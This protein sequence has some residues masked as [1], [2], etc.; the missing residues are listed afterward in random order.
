MEVNL[1][2]L[3]EIQLKNGQILKLRKPVANDAEKMIE[4]LN[5]VGGESDNLLFGKGEFLLTVEQEVE[6]INRI[7]NDTNT[8]MIVGIIND[9]IVSVAQIS[10]PSRK[11]I[12][13]NSE[14]AISVRRDYWGVGIGS[15][16]MEELIQFAKKHSIIKNISL[17]VK[18]SNSKAIR[19]YEKYGFVKVGVHKNYFYVNGSYDDE[20]L[21][22]LYI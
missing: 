10:S 13:H 17:G 20:I 3:K 21:M 18:A 5:T 19:L 11:R 4:Y 14:L 12:S 22:D 9:S 2:I 15:A 7:N 8:F 6:Y 1:P 16:L